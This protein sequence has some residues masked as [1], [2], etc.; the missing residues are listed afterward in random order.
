MCAFGA[1]YSM[2]GRVLEASVVPA[3]PFWLEVSEHF[4][5][6]SRFQEKQG[7][8]MCKASYRSA[9]HYRSRAEECR[10]IAGL[11]LEQ[12]NHDQLLKVAADYDFMAD[13]VDGLA[14]APDELDERTPAHTRSAKYFGK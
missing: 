9:E 12:D 5:T 10:T 11:F 2:K 14:V 6:V 8:V 13:T 3:L 7:P 1:A 4:R